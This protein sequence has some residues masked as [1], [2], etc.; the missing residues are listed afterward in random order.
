MDLRPSPFIPMCKKPAAP[1]TQVLRATWPRG[2]GPPHGRRT[3]RVISRP[4]WNGGYRAYSGP[5]R[6]DPWRPAF[7]PYETIAGRSATT[8]LEPLLPFKIGPMNGREARE[9]GL[10]LKAWVAP[11]PVIPQFDFGADTS[12]GVTARMATQASQLCRH[13]SRKQK[14]R[15]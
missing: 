9:S 5:S 14:V 10:S 11:R 1:R 6:G 7:R 13:F 3:A 8:A 2:A 4:R 12:S 15:I